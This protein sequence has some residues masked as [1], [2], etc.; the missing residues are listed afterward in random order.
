MSTVP[1]G[2]PRHVFGFN[3]KTSILAD[4]GFEFKE[5]VS[6]D[7]HHFNTLV[8]PGWSHRIY[9]LRP[10]PFRFSYKAFTLQD[11]CYVDYADCIGG[12]RLEAATLENFHIGFVS[13]EELRLLGARADEVMLTVTPPGCGWEAAGRVGGAGLSLNLMVDALRARIGQSAY[14]RTMEHVRRSCCGGMLVRRLVEGPPTRLRRLL[15]ELL[16]EH[17]GNSDITVTHSRL[18][19][20]EWEIFEHVYE[21]M[22]FIAG[23]CGETESS[24]LTRRATLAREAE[25]LLWRNAFSDKSGVPYSLEDLA[26]YLG[27]SSRT[28]QLA[29]QEYFGYSFR[30]MS[31][32]IRLHSARERI[33]DAKTADRDSIAAVACAYGFWHVGRFSTYYTRLFGRRPSED[34]QRTRS[35]RTLVKRTFL[36]YGKP[37]APHDSD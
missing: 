25:H 8:K 14:S 17:D 1:V 15:I 35:S 19:Q 23:A 9:Q 30:E 33:L 6:T 7:P 18:R 3:M 34:V 13:G 20:L 37:P 5:T 16:A 31:I 36:K 21:M 28:L 10:G 4:A 26:A 32:G 24:T 29:L 11:G 27:V 22:S 12:S 2:Q